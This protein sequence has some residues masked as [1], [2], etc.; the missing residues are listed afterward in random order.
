MTSCRETRRVLERYLAFE[1]PAADEQAVRAHLAS[2]PA[3][4]AE[5]ESRDP[6][7]AL[8]VAFGASS[9]E[10]GGEEF[11]QAVL[12]GIHQRRAERVVGS[13][14]RLWGSA[15]AAALLAI[16]V[17]PLWRSARPW[18]A[19][20][21]EAESAVAVTS[22]VEPAF[23]EVEGDAVRVYQLVSAEAGAARVALIVDP[24]LE[25]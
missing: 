24:E 8:A 16:A 13:R 5:L 21:S 3:C 1:L 10:G 11:V 19:P 7:A 2:C 12:A 9:E 14:R 20:T 15:A 17:L 25:L 6:G 4:L 23:V 22:N 18:L